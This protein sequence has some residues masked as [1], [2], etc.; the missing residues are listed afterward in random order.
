[1][2]GLLLGHSRSYLSLLF[3]GAEIQVTYITLRNLEDVQ[4]ALLWRRM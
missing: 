2:Q 1:M 4:P 3:S